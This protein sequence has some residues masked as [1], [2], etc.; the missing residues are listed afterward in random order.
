MNIREL[1]CIGCPM[2]CQLRATL[3]DGV[4][5]AVTGNT[6]PRGDAYARKECV[7]PERTVTGT[8]RVLGGP[9]PVVPVRTQGEVPKEK[10]LEVARALHHAAVPAPVQAGQVVLADVCG[11][12][13]AVVAKDKGTCRGITLRDLAIHD[14]NGNVYDK[15]MNNGGIY[16]TALSPADEAATGPARFADV[17]VEGCYLYRVSRWGLAVGYT[18]AHAHFQGAALEEAPFL[19]YGHENVTIRDNYVKLAGSDGITV[20]YALRPLVE[21]NTADSVACEINDRVYSHPGD[22]AGKVAAGIWPWKCKDALFRCNEAADTRLNQD[23]MA[24]DADS[25]DGTVYEYNFSRQNEGG[26]VMFCLQE[27]IHNTFRH[28]VSFDDLGGTISPSENPDALITD[29]VFYV[30]DG[31]PFVRPQMGGGNYTAENN[32]FLPLDKFTP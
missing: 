21:H 7:H 15:H 16:M 14:V 13:V 6:C 31:V 23:S 1:T 24:Y 20:M 10:V 18:Y 4:V 5:T 3:E 22:R 32:T 11:T 26:C 12:G 29:N 27:A 8:V 2:G 17:L 30:R 25:G 19:K 28:N 9:L